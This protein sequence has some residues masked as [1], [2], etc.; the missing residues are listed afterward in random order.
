MVSSI[1]LFDELIRLGLGNTTAYQNARQ[2]VWT[3]MMT[4]P[5][6]NNAWANYFEDVP[7][8]TGLGNINQINPMML[9]RY[10]MEHPEKDSNWETHVRGLIAWS[11]AT[12]LPLNMAPTPLRSRMH[13]CM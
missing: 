3:W 1:E 7:I 6:Q 4:F 5:M 13:S 12:S 11:T 9:A 10:L 2:T 8:Q